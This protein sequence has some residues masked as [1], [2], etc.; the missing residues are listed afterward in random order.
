MPKNVVAAP[1]ITDGPIS[2]RASAI[3]ASFGTLGSWFYT[4]G[5]GREAGGGG[6]VPAAVLEYTISVPRK[7]VTT[8]PLQLESRFGTNL[9]R[10][11]IRRGVRALHGLG[12]R[13]GAGAGG[14]G[15]GS[16]QQR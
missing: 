12:G 15:G 6:C 16:Q 5:R 9:L 7:S 4:G 3:R 11:S 14:V 2:P 1:T 10:I 13:E 8:M